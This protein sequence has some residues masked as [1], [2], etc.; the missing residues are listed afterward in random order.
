[1]DFLDIPSVPFSDPSL[2]TGAPPLGA[3]DGHAAAVSSDG[4]RSRSEGTGRFRQGGEY[5]F[6]RDAFA[7]GAVDLV[8]LLTF[9]VRFLLLVEEGVGGGSHWTH[10]EVIDDGSQRSVEWTKLGLPNT[11][12]IWGDHDRVEVKDERRGTFGILRT[13]RHWYGVG[14]E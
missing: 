10:G 3:A 13:A 14:G 4:G 7:E 9:C 5:E 8:Y 2:G 6:G 12:V 1:L 11:M